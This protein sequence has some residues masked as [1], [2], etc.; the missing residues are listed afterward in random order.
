MVND[1]IITVI[2]FVASSLT[3]ISLLPQTIKTLASRSTKD[4][5]LPMYIIMNIGICVWIIYGSFLHEL[6][7]IIGNGITL[8][9][10]MPIL[11][12]SIVNFAKSHR[13]SK[14]ELVESTASTP[15]ELKID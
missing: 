11:T 4:I 15:P 6:P 14:K 9:F 13:N 1:T 10:S 5:S 3:T 2:G 7:I 8:A 12:I